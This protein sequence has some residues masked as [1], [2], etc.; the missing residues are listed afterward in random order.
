MSA[1]VVA[2]RLT[3]RDQRPRVASEH[4][5]CFG[6]PLGELF[7]GF[8]HRLQAVSVVPASSARACAEA[9]VVG[10]VVDA[11]PASTHSDAS[12][13]P[14]TPEAAREWTVGFSGVADAVKEVRSLAAFALLTSRT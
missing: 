7:P 4:L 8:A 9:K 6:R 2:K 13:A 10:D 3:R 1:R 11:D 5:S 12:D 14:G